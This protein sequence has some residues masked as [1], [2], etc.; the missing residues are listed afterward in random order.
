LLCIIDK[1]T[2]INDHNIVI[3][4]IGLMTGINAVSTKLGEEHFGIHQI[5]GATHGDDIDF[6]FF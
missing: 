4:R 3:I 2:G 1:A 5:L 6:V